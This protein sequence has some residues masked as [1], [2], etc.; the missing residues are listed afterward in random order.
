MS[1]LLLLSLKSLSQV[2]YCRVLFVLIVITIEIL[3]F[4]VMLMFKL[5]SFFYWSGMCRLR[6]D[7]SVSNVITNTI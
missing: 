7:G 6:R 1:S 4:V 2:F 3:I 5:Y